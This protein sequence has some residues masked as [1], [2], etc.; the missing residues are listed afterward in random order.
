VNP[1]Q[2]LEIIETKNI[3]EFGNPQESRRISPQ[4]W[5]QKYQENIDSTI[6]IDDTEYKLPKSNFKV[7]GIGKQFLT[8]SIR[9]LLAK[10]TNRQ[11]LLVNF[12]EAP[13]LAFI[14]GYFSKYIGEA[15]YIF[16]QNKN[17]PV[18]LFMSIVV[19]L[20]LGIT[21][22][23]EEI[24]SDRKIL[25]R[26]SFLNLSRTTYLNSKITYL[27]IL[28]AVQTLSFVLVGNTILEIRGMLLSFW[29][30]LFTTSCLGNMI[31]LNISAGLNSVV[32][33]YILI[34]LIL[35]PQL[36]LGGAM[37]HFDD[38]HK[39][40]THKEYV[41]VVGD[42][43]TTR[44]AYEAMAVEQF[45]NNEFEKL[46][47]EQEQIISSASYITSF[48]IPQ[49]EIKIEECFRSM[50][51]EDNQSIL[52][53]NL[54]I[55]QNEL[56]RLYRFYDFYPYEGIEDLT[57]ER[58]T[59]EVGEQTTEFLNLAKIFFS[60]IAQEANSRKDNIYNNLVDSLGTD[61][62]YR[63]KQKYYNNK[64]AD[65]VTNRTAVNKIVEM[66]D[67]MVRKKDPIFMM[68]ESNVGRAHFYAPYKM[69]NGKYIE[70]K[71]FNLFFI[72]LTTIALYLTLIMDL[73]RK[74]ITYFENIK[75][76]KE[77]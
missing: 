17:L 63:F 30:I 28:S 8:F 4:E 62:V 16:E 77:R 72:W 74:V 56:N 39:S 21:V 51:E 7:A 68:P 55:I 71:W 1:D 19:A 33:I 14:L 57:P 32:T 50:E 64:L 70:T 61:G 2:I 47:F 34:P 75:L 29:L 42:L 24:I 41:P 66:D 38:L 67:R 53:K 49:L 23:A 37:I 58:F 35:V 13:L 52:A 65:I 44:W 73:L 59:P 5:F 15:G 12:F 69:I 40:L 60:E 27:F 3:D 31:G 9:N 43:M 20:F 76:R 36:L 45:K 10:L 25:E 6:T 11:Y 18:F 46:F 54:A 48:L 22:S 26:E